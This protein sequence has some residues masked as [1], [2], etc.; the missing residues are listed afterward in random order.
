MNRLLTALSVCA[1]F[2]VGLAVPHPSLTAA[3]AGA[4]PTQ[5]WN[6]H[7]DAEKHF[8]DAHPTEIAHHWCKAVANGMTE[9]QI[10]SSDASDAQLVA[11]ETIVPPA[12]YKSFN[13]QEQALWHYH[14]D[15][16]PKVNAKMPDMTPDQAKKVV[17]SIMD[18]YGKI[19]LL[20]DPLST[21]GM[22][23]GQPTVTVLR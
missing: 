12:A 6:L 10:Y 18:T 13:A 23:T 4:G 17:S 14:K 20:Y 8:G 5:G 1:A 19:W 16:I 9:C 15:E 22:P 21:N 11:V 2:L 7:I 3:A